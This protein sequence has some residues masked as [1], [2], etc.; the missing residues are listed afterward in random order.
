MNDIEY[1]YLLQEREFINAKQNIYKV[2]MTKTE[3][4]VRFKQY[5]KGS[6]LL[7]QIICSNCNKMEKDVLK[8][9]K[10]IFKQ[11]KDI[12]TEYFEG[13][14]TKMIDIIY[15]IVK[16]ECENDEE[17]QTLII[18]KYEDWSKYNGI[19]NIIITTQNG[20]GFLRFEGQ[21]WRE[22]GPDKEENLLEY[23]EHWHNDVVTH[24]HTEYNVN[25][26]F[27]DIIKKCVVKKPTFFNLDYHDYILKSKNNSL[28]YVLF[29]SITFTFI[30]VDKLINNKILTE[31]DCGERFVSVKNIVNI[32]VVNDILN[33]LIPNEIKIQYKELV[34]DLIVEKREQREP[35]VFYDYNNCLLTSWIRSVLDTISNTK[36][37]IDSYEYYDNKL[38]VKTLLKT[39]RCVIIKKYPNITIKNQI[40][41]F[42]RLGIKNIIV[43]QKD[44]KNTM[45]NISNFRKYLNDNKE[46]LLKCIKEENDCEFRSHDWEK[47][48]DTK[49]FDDDI[50]YNSDLLWTN[51][52]KWCCVK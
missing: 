45:Y 26:I 8:K 29:N 51:F 9:F 21:L 33:S 52:L 4:L 42:S 10:E 36:F 2:G 5:P 24:T 40:D 22:I 46:S 43:C 31:K 19:N 48:W 3:N 1:I 6:V 13:E 30:P 7:F 49:L 15:D 47:L 28:L 50:F 25:E 23:I 34:Y 41:E 39:L 37:Y 27:K 14:Y 16:N 38:E 32:D 12:G 44:E 11:R 35:I 20:E 18:T 17:E